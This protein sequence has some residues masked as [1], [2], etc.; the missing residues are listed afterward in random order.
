MAP[1][2][3]GRHRASCPAMLDGM[4]EHQTDALDDLD[5]EQPTLEKAK[6]GANW[7][8]AHIDLDTRLGRPRPVSMKFLSHD[9][10]MI[11][12]EVTRNISM[13]LVPTHVAT[14]AEMYKSKS[15]PV[16]GPDVA[17]LLRE[18]S[19]STRKVGSPS[20]SS[21]NVNIASQ[22]CSYCCHCWSG[23][24][25]ALPWR[26]S[27]PAS[28]PDFH[29]PE[30]SVIIFD[31]DDTL[32]P[33]TY[34]LQDLM[35]T[36]L[37]NE[38]PVTED[39]ECFAALQ[40]HAHVVE[41]MLRTAR[42]F[43]RVAIITNSLEPWVIASAKNYLPGLDM[44]SLLA[45]L[46]IQ[47][48][49]SRRRVPSIPV[50]YSPHEFDISIDRRQKGKIGLAIAPQESGELLIS[51]VKPGGLVEEWNVLHP[52]HVVQPG[53]CIVAVDG[54]SEK[55]VQACRKMELLQVRIRREVPDRN[56]FEVAKQLDM[57]DCLKA[58]YGSRPWRWNVVSIGDSLIEQNALKREL[59]S[60][61]A[62][63]TLSGY[64]P[65]C[66]TV[67]MLDLPTMEQVGCQ[68]KLLMLWFDHIIRHEE[69]F[70]LFMDKLDDIEMSLFERMQSPRSPR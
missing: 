62:R 65:L 32:L 56:V 5:G 36:E 37:E 31:W 64:K 19:S 52:N 69:D 10:K 44:G 12:E 38:G 51:Q 46:G 17:L 35:Q 23:L 3:M 61:A 30:S 68:L 6:S 70:D 33:T 27:V 26:S 4:A 16:F 58:L 15:A 45:E 11:R 40:A 1:L 49:Y 28:M 53:D 7:F 50:K 48:Y 2:A 8:D 63:N 67:N 18:E 9:D 54:S 29:S 59:Q 13:R 34:I 24:L 14:S 60:H 43:A 55:L 25:A 47:V 22:R 66:K 21:S 20:A 39:M 41:A 42:R 57:V